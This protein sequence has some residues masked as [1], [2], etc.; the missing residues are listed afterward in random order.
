MSDVLASEGDRYGPS[1]I[2]TSLNGISCA[3]GAHGRSLPRAIGQH[4]SDHVAD[5]RTRFASHGE[6]PRLM[7]HG[8]YQGDN[9][10]LKQ[11]TLLG[12]VDY[13]KASHQKRRA[14]V[15]EA[16]IYFSSHQERL[17]QRLA[18]PGGREW[19]P[20][21]SFLASYATAAQLTDRESLAL[22]DYIRCIRTWRR[23]LPWQTGPETML[24]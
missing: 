7:A 9:Y 20:F 13:D 22:P 19:T 18:Y 5:L 21:S 6:L 15:A 23:L 3:L 4:V 12:V 8:D 16:L 1:H 2:A 24:T 10:L 17:L 11:D 14:E